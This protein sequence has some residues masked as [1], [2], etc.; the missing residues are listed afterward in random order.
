MSSRAKSDGYSES[1]GPAPAAGT[2]VLAL[3]NPLRGDDGV[4]LAVLDRLA[5]N[6]TF[7]DDVTLLDSDALALDMLFTIHR[8][9]QVVIVDAGNLGQN[10]GAWGCFPPDRL[11]MPAWGNESCSIHNAGLAEAL[12]VGKKLNLLPSSL[13]FV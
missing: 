8:Y 5:A 1:G 13:V 6:A 3:G 9:R 11:A 4:G 12:A 7:P 2:L 10:P